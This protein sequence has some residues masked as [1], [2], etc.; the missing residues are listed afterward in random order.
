[1]TSFD[2]CIIGAGPAGLKAGIAAASSG[3][4]VILIEKNP[5]AGEKL[6]L[7]GKGRC[8]LAHAV[9]S[10][11]DIIEA[12]RE[13]GR[14]LHSAL[15]R[16]GFEETLAFFASL[17]LPLKTER[18]KRVF[19]GSGGAQ[20]VRNRLMEAFRQ[21]GGI[22]RGRSPVA[23]LATED[24]QIDGAVLHDGS[25]I[26]AGRYIV[27]TGGLSYPRTGSTGDGYR[28]AKAM[29]HTVTETIPA[30]VPVRLADEWIPEVSGLSLK[31]VRL[32]LFTGKKEI[33][34]RFGD[35]DFT[36][37]G[38]S[39]PIGMDL[40]RAIG[41]ALRNHDKALLSLDLK[42]AVDAS[43]LDKRLLRELDGAA[44]ADFGMVLKTLLPRKLI[45]PFARLCSVPIDRKAATLTKKERLQVLRLLKALPLKP[46]SLLGFE[47]SLVTSGGILLD[48]VDPR[49]MASKLVE[50]LYFAGEILDLDAPTGG[51]NLQACWTTGHVAGV[52]AASGAFFGHRNS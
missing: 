10:E 17:R 30:L 44:S 27:T 16:F 50:N 51:Y 42:P 18:G 3:A 15:S 38:I 40:S 8:N 52:S 20:D 46:M 13:N 6:L 2:I 4:R 24:G 29:G 33:E 47:W 22:F 11:K 37:F 32:T 35:L 1:M 36:P 12:F 28:W 21:G 25:I 5:E 31:N 9:K 19:P 7:T 39:G 14:F 34:S 45:T 43:T 49:T 41:K 23:D 26:K 48:E